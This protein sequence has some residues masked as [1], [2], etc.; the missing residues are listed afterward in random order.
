MLKTG[1]MLLILACL[2]MVGY[3][4]YHAIAALLAAPGISLVAKVLILCAGLGVIL[5]L[6]GLWIEKRREAAHAA[7]DNEHD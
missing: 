6:I 4:G 7:R 3:G 1:Y 2:G 5:I